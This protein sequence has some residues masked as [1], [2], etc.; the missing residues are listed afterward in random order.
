VVDDKVIAIPIVAAGTLAV[1]VTAA[2][3]WHAR[4]TA[5]IAH[6]AFGPRGRPAMWAYAAPVI[7]VLGMAAVCWGAATLWLMDPK[8]HALNP[9]EL[10]AIDENEIRH[11]VFVLDVSPSMLLQ[12]AGTNGDQSRRK[13]G[14]AVVKSFM[15]RIPYAHYRTTIVAVYNGAK[16]VVEE[17]TDGE[18]IHNILNDLPMRFAFRPGK[19]NLF[20]GLEEVARIARPWRPK[21][22]TVILV[23]DGDTVPATGMPKMPASVAD[24]LVVGIGDPVS[25]KFIAGTMSRQDTSTLRQIAARLGG[26]YYNANQ[27]QIPTTALR[28]LTRNPEESP[29]EKLTRR[30]YALI[31]LCLGAS[32]MALLPILLEYF[33]TFWKPGV[34]ARRLH[35]KRIVTTTPNYGEKGSTFERQTV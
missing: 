24:V 19:T 14:A 5:R 33:G 35:Q 34:P 6:L 2:E 4:R 25:G 22:T 7:R 11:L 26:S 23:S 3:I 32:L 10:A 15:E 17:S 18:V 31:A 21:S 12:D 20:S 13:R 9:D 30:E 28:G 16:P 8:V 1:L 29:F 27:K